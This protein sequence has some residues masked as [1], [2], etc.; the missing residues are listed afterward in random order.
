MWIFFQ[1]TRR[2][3]PTKGVPLLE[4]SCEATKSPKGCRLFLALL[5][6]SVGC[7]KTD[8]HGDALV[9]DDEV[10][11]AKESELVSAVR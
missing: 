10:A 1:Q 11:V 6:E 5:G 7:A 9:G 3:T 4:S 2:D 8:E